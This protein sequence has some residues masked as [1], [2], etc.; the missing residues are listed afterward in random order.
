[1]RIGLTKENR[2]WLKRL[3]T[4]KSALYFRGREAQKIMNAFIN[5][6]L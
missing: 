5:S 3:I 4:P 1:V 2:E 6:D